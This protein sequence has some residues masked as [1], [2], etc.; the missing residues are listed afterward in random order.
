MFI[1]FRTAH[2]SV[3][4]VCRA[5]DLGLGKCGIY[6]KKGWIPAGPNTCKI[7]LCINHLHV[8]MFRQIS[9]SNHTTIY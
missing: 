4:V 7:K 3:C 8:A 1:R 5:E 6:S 2:I 9:N